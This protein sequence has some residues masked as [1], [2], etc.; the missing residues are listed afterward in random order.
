MSPDTR[1]LLPTRRLSSVSVVPARGTPR[2]KAA[3]QAHA[4]RRAARKE[5]TPS[6]WSE[7]IGPS[8][9]DPALLRAQ[10]LKPQWSVAK[11]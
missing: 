10:L 7:E 6:D 8:A 11:S 3:E 5:R 9:L 2:R 4:S 1:S